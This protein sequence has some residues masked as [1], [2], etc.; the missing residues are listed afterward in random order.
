[1]RILITGISGFVGGHLVEALVSAGGH[2][3][4]GVVRQDSQLLAHPPADFHPSVELHTGDL[5]DGKRV[6]EVVRGV[7]PEWVFHLAGYANTGGSFREPDR[8]WA[9]NLAATRSLYDA[10][11]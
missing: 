11:A 4:A 10:I 2:A 3:L 6:E 9:D 8:C 5:H 7:K 1:M